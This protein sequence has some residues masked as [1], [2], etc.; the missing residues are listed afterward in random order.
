MLVDIYLN[1]KFP[2]IT[3]LLSGKGYYVHIIHRMWIHMNT[4]RWHIN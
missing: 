1:V 4:L 3:V 2:P